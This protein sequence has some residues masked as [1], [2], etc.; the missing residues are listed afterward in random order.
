MPMSAFLS[1]ANIVAGGK[2]VPLAPLI[3][4]VSISGSGMMGLSDASVVV[5]T[6]TVP[7]SGFLAGVSTSGLGA[8]TTGVGLGGIIVSFGGFAGTS[9]P[10]ASSTGLSGTGVGGNGGIFLGGSPGLKVDTSI[11]VVGMAAFGGVILTLA[12]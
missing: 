9:T 12:L 7:L 3:T 10:G 6:Q 8:A 1:G 11:W 2:T 5:G 4:G